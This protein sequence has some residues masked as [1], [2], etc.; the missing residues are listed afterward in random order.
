MALASFTW[1]RSSLDCVIQK[2]GRRK[3]KSLGLVNT[4][5]QD[6]VRS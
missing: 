1:Q 3:K 4:S 5:Q 2:M 6:N